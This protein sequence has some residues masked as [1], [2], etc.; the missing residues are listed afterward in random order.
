[1]IKRRCFMGLVLLVIGCDNRP[2]LY[3]SFSDISQG[4]GVRSWLPDFF[5]TSATNIRL[6]SNVDLNTFSAYFSLPFDEEIKL[7]DSAKKTSV[8]SNGVGYIKQQEKNV[9]SVVCMRTDYNLFYEEVRKYY[10]VGELKNKGEYYLISVS[11]SQY[12]EFC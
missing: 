1:M 12:K 11:N 9:V 8:S 10:M 6:T 3:G 2:Q 4:D 5:P 7:S